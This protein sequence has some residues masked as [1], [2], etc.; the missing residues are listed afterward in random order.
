MS[1]SRAISSSVDIRSRRRPTHGRTRF[2]SPS[3]SSSIPEAV[4]Q[5]RKL[6][7]IEPAKVKPRLREVR[8]R[9]PARDLLAQRRRRAGHAE[10]PRHP[11]SAAPARSTSEMARAKHAEVP[12]FQQEGTTCC[13]AKAD[14]YLGQ[15]R[16]RHSVGDVHAA[17]GRRS[18]DRSRPRASARFSVSRAPTL[19]RTRRRAARRGRARRRG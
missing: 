5:Y 7:G 11:L 16:G 9:R 12:L 19:R 10:P 17:R 2:T 8:D 6:L 13:Y 4:E 3:T 1:M 18:G 15:G 14:K